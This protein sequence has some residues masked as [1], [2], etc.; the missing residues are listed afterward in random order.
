MDFRAL[1]AP[2]ITDP[3][4]LRDFADALGDRA[5]EIEGQI[6]RLKKQPG[7]RAVLD[8]LFRACHNL[9]G[10]AGLCGFALAGVI[11][12][13]IENLLSRLRQGE[14]AFGER[15]ADI[16]L[17]A[18]DRLELATEA[19]LAGNSLQPQKLPELLQGLEKLAAVAPDLLNSQCS[20]LIEQITGF[21]PTVFA[22]PSP[23]FADL[24]EPETGNAQLA[25]DLHFFRAL[26]LQFESRAPVFKGRTA[27]ILRLAL[28]TNKLTGNPVNPLQLEAALYMH[29]VGMMF[30]PE[31]VWL[32]SGRMSPEEKILLHTH[33]GFAAG[34]L[35]RMPGWGEAARM[36]AQH[37]ELP[38]GGGYPNNLKGNEVCAGARLIAVVDAFEAVMLKHLHRGKNRSVLRAIAE[39]NAC[40]NQFAPEWIAPFNSVIRFA[41]SM[42]SGN[43]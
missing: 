41:L 22:P 42:E 7:D 34:L 29:D 23:H 4:V 43:V 21:P 24:R 13:N 38:D 8:T 17:L 3:L 12:H 9:K 26:A 30:L 5:A 11:V 18:L 37:H 40:N 36:V 10:D 25:A 14:I 1:L 2:V 28:E 39:I 19:V 27:R 31:P 33:P 20:L 32:K 35:E 16:I 15:L 6:A